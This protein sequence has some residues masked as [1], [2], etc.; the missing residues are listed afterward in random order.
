M[1]FGMKGLQGIVFLVNIGSDFGFF[2][3]KTWLLIGEDCFLSNKKK[4]D[5]IKNSYLNLEI[6]QMYCLHL[7]GPNYM[8]NKVYKKQ[9]H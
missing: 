3:D 7:K 4:L 6:S 8:K 9:K 5:I 1:H 2:G